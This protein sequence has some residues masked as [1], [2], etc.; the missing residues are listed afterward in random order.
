[1]LLVDVE[2]SEDEF[3]NLV[4]CGKECVEQAVEAWWVG[5]WIVGAAE[6]ATLFAIRRREPDARATWRNIHLKFRYKK[7]I[8]KCS[9]G[10]FSMT[11]VINYKFRLR[12]LSK[13]LI[14]R[15]NHVVSFG[16]WAV[17]R[18]IPSPILSFLASLSYLLLQK[19]IPVIFL[20]LHDQHN[21][22][23]SI[24][25]N[26]TTILY[27]QT[28]ENARNFPVPFKDPETPILQNI[29]PW[30]LQNKKITE[31][32]RSSRHSDTCQ[33][34]ITWFPWGQVCRITYCK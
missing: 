19:W 8:L 23:L 30:Y 13:K 28:R 1:M 16:E 5:A 15:Q 31:H 2:V 24:Q 12:C 26:I 21:C 25:N 17:R 27:Y 10:H 3:N 7:C 9:D 22:L 18:S 4:R 33:E 32:I 20:L 34:S 29:N 11:V 6:R 14:L